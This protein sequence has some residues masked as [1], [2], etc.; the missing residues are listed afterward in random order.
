MD[1]K[2]WIKN[3]IDSNDFYKGLAFAAIVYVL[4]FCFMLIIRWMI[5]SVLTIN[6]ID[7]SMIR[8]SIASVIIPVILWRRAINRG[9]EKQGRAIILFCFLAIIISFLMLN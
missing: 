8:M 9:L 1:M 3:W 5:T 2:N 7:L 4:S 6:S